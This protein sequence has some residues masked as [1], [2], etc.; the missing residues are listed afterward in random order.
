MKFYVGVALVLVFLG[1]YGLYKEAKINEERVELG[2]AL[3]FGFATAIL[4]GLI[5]FVFF[6]LGSVIATEVATTTEVK[7]F[8]KPIYSLQDNMGTNARFTIGRGY[9]DSTLRY[10]FL[11]NTKYGYKVESVNSNEAY[12]LLDGQNKIEF[13]NLR[14]ENKIVE[15]LFD[16]CSEKSTFY[17][18]HI[19]KDTIEKNYNIDLQ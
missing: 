14:F 3:F 7:Y 2:E 16:N 18:L 10:Y 9:V 8:E 13:Y 5:C 17:V 4:S 6:A 12:L 1:M 11:A 19:P 15:Y